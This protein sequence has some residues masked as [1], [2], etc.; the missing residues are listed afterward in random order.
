MKGILFGWNNWQ[1]V[2]IAWSSALTLLFLNIIFLNSKKKKKIKRCVYSLCGEWA[3]CA[4]LVFIAD[5][6]RVNERSNWNTAG[7][8]ET[9][10]ARWQLDPWQMISQE[11][12]S[13]GY[14]DYIFQSHSSHRRRECISHPQND[15]SQFKGLKGFN[16]RIHHILIWPILRT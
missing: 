1:D 7:Q 2:V 6:N 10:T 15:R 13:I 9:W 4:G 5:V 8:M 16:P 12:A 3:L 14:A 11:E